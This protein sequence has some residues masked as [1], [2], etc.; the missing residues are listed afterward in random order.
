MS[1]LRLI[2]L[3][4]LRSVGFFGF[5]AICGCVSLSANVAAADYVTVSLRNAELQL[6]L[7]SEERESEV[8]FRAS[9]TALTIGDVAV[10][11]GSTSLRS[12]IKGLDLESVDRQG[13]VFTVTRRQI[14]MR[15]L[16]EGIR[17][18]EFSLDGER[19]CVVR[20]EQPQNAATLVEE[21]IA[22]E[23]ERQFARQRSSVSVSLVSDSQIQGLSGRHF[24]RRVAPKVF[25]PNQLPIGRSR[26]QLE[27][28]D[29]RG[30]RS[31]Q[32][33]DVVVA[34]TMQVA[35]AKE[36]IQRG[37]VIDEKMVSLIERPIS[38]RGD[39]AEP[40][41]LI[42]RNAT[43][44]IAA[45]QVV[46]SNYVAGPTSKTQ[47]VAPE[48]PLLVRAGEYIDV[49]ARFGSNEVRLKNAKSLSAGREGEVITV[50]NPR[51]NK[52]LTATVVSSKLAQVLI[53]P[54]K[55]Q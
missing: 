49:V 24:S 23:I 3:S 20:I 27:F 10:V 18:S 34:V 6:P 41:L 26:V 12:R 1:A 7:V 36:R 29:E 46:L 13:Q 48:K 38:K 53:G 30:M 11:E 14:E 54:G 37:K 5:V 51:S 47:P 45:H 39:F 35:I 31:L 8:S 50:L 21:H 52:R 28:D 22:K 19:E 25:L 9:N 17:R 4:I 55:A 43:R 40:Q 16:L 44:D 32:D 2:G 15:I 33:V 42:G